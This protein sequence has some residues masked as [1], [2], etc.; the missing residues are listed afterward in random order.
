MSKTGLTKNELLQRMARRYREECG[1]EDGAMES[2]AFAD[3]LLAQGW[4]A[5]RPRTAKELVIRDIGRAMRSEYRRDDV[6]GFP[7][8]ANIAYRTTEQ[9]TGEQMTFWVDPDIAPKKQVHLALTQ[10]RNQILGDVMGLANDRDHYNRVRGE[11]EGP[12]NMTFD[13]DLDVE[14]ERALCRNGE[15]TE[16]DD[17]DDDKL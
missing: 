7:Y 9:R 13:F 6:G 12:I 10:R 5:P 16:N 8:R 11:A 2:S 4:V 17:S 3:W 14:E 15:S 1:L